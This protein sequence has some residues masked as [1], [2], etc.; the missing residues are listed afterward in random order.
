MLKTAIYGSVLV[1]LGMNA[2]L[3]AASVQ[4][5]TI[6]V[7]LPRS[8]P[9]VNA[10]PALPSQSLQPAPL[11]QTDDG[12]SEAGSAFKGCQADLRRRGVVFEVP[13][14]IRHAKGC[15][16]P[17]PVLLLA[18]DARG[19]AIALPGRPVLNC[20]FAL[21]LATWLADVT[22]PVVKSF[23]RSPLISVATGPGYVCR[24]RNN[25]KR[26]KISEHASGN[27]IDITSFRISTRKTIQVSA[28]PNGPPQQVRLLSALRTSSCG[29]FTTVLGPG[30]NAAHKSHFHL[31]YGKHGRTWNYR[32]CE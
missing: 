19:S 25:Q 18:V 30:A 15:G 6:P 27:A 24:N 17:D 12:T 32:I 28:I 16:V 13:A 14:P 1:L 2:P 26:G 20:K 22:G 5:G 21:R 7:P 29:Y 11:L 23:T 31:D 8:K 4:Q 10:S 3:Q 9:P